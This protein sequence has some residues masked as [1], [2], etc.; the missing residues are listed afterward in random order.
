VCEEYQAAQ[1]YKDHNWGT[2]SGVTWEW[3]ATRAGKYGILYGVV[4][5][6]ES[7]AE[8]APLFLY[9]VDS[10]GFRALFRPRRITYEDERTILVDG[11][12]VRVPSRAVLAD[13]RGAD[14]I[15]LELEIEDAIGS[16]VRRTLLERGAVLPR[17]F[18]IQMKGRARLSGFVSGQRLAGEG[19]GFFETYR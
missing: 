13:V 3:G 6:P 1:S 9:V 17:P 8:E 19:T 15:R 11:R 16:D 14:T 2:W 7:N 12:E 18:F 10:L 5:A 4:H